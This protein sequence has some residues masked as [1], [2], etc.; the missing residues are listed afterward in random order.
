[1][2]FKDHMPL[3]WI[4]KLTRWEHREKVDLRNWGV[5]GI[6]LYSE[7]LGNRTA[8]SQPLEE[9]ARLRICTLSAEQHRAGGW[10]LHRLRE[11]KV[12]GP[13]Q[14]GPK[15]S[16]LVSIRQGELGARTD[17]EI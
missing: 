10:A 17:V 6:W 4:G 15:C 12:P 2:S 3:A 7:G 11:L 14:V 13:S 1:M 5:L 16:S 9:D 8:W